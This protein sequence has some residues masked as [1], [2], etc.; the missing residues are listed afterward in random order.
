MSLVTFAH[1]VDRLCDALTITVP[2]VLVW[3]AIGPGRGTLLA[4]LAAASLPMLSQSIVLALD[5]GLE[6][7][8]HFHF[9]GSPSQW[10]FISLGLGLMYSLLLFVLMSVL[11]WVPRAIRALRNRWTG[12]GESAALPA[13]RVRRRPRASPPR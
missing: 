1:A 2:I 7:G 8:G 13:A 11:K 3:Q 10:L 12:R 6:G 5:P 9:R 4:T